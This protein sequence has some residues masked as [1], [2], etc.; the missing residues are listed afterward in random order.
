MYSPY[1]PKCKEPEL[2]L[3]YLDDEAI[4][5]LREIPQY[6][7]TTIRY[8]SIDTRI[9]IEVVRMILTE[10]KK[11]GLVTLQTL[12]QYEENYLCGSSY[13]LTPMGTKVLELLHEGY[14]HDYSSNYDS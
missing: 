9:H 4:K 10:L 7:S 12:F 1:F 5:V 6:N 11:L 13:C 14:K 3:R 2:V 8:M